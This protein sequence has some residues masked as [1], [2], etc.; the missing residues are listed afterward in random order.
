MC[1]ISI[2]GDGEIELLH[3]KRTNYE[4]GN[5]W[6]HST[7]KE[8]SVRDFFK[9]DLCPSLEDLRGYNL[10]IYHGSCSKYYLKSANIEN[11]G[12]MAGCKRVF[13]EEIKTYEKVSK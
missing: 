6:F 1:Y 11:F 10:T 12:Y 13:I 8:G 5:K 7:T 4:D 9:E 2:L 3:K